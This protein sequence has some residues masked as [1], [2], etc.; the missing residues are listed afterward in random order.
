MNAKC[1]IKILLLYEFIEKFNGHKLINF[2]RMEN[3][4]KT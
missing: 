4:N 3:E 2:I 1:I